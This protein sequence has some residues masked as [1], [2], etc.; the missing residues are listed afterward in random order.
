MF[1]FMTETVIVTQFIFI[2]MMDVYFFA[3]AI[4]WLW[5]KTRKK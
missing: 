1:E 4:R 2:V 3:K 5:G